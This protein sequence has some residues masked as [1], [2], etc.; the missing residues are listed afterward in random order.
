LRRPHRVAQGAG[1]QGQVPGAVVE[2]KGAP[3]VPSLQC[4]FG[5]GREQP[6]EAARS[7][8][9]TN[10]ARDFGKL[11]PLDSASWQNRSVSKRRRTFRLERFTGQVR[12]RRENGYTERSETGNDDQSILITDTR[13]EVLENGFAGIA[14]SWVFP[15]IVS[16]VQPSRDGAE[17]WIRAGRP[18]K[19][20]T[21]IRTPERA[22]RTHS[23]SQSAR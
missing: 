4:G 5:G 10:R 8:P 18:H 12:Q 2:R 6:D 13:A 3:R 14:I 19:N 22:G 20:Q 15:A 7:A 16:P 17:R 23:V 11:A 21:K 1:I 9:A